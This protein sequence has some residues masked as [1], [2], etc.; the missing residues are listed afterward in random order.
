MKK[1]IQH[2]KS[3][4][5]VLFLMI[6]VNANSQEQKNV[7]AIKTTTMSITSESEAQVKAKA[8][9]YMYKNN[10]SVNNYT[11]SYTLQKV[12]RVNESYSQKFN[13][14]WR[15]IEREIKRYNYNYVKFLIEKE[16][17]LKEYSRLKSRQSSKNNLKR[18]GILNIMQSQQS[19]ATQIWRAK[20]SGRN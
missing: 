13:T 8:A 16:Y 7:L 12:Q 17:L 6:S 14:H 5:V 20:L 9:I 1:N 11:G 19:L 3:I 10:L 18:V 15:N 4:A 2:L